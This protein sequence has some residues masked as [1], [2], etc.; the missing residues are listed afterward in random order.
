MGNAQHIDMLNK[1]VRI[2]N[3]W[4]RDNAITPDLSQTD[5]TGANLIGAYLVEANLNN[6]IL[7]DADI[8]NANLTKAQLNNASLVESDLSRATLIEAQ[9]DGADLNHTN[10]GH[11]N[12]R[13]ASL[14]KADLS[15]AILRNAN[16]SDVQLTEANLHS[17]GLTYADFTDAKLIGANLR[18]AL[19]GWT[20]LANTDISV[21]KGL[22]AIT[23]RGPSTV[24][25]D[26]LY[27]SRGDIPVVFLQGCGVP[28]EFITYLPSLVGA[29]QAIQFYSCFISYS[30]R[31]EEFSKRLHSRMRDAHLRVWYA[32]EDI[33][34]G[35]KL[36]EQIDTAIQLHDRLVLVLSENSLQSEWVMT[37]IRKA[38]KIENKE[39]RRKLFPIRLTDMETIRKWECFDADIGK[40]L[41]IEV[42]EYYIPDFS[43]WKNHDSFE[44]AF[45]RLLRDLKAEELNQRRA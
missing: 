2:W 26:T 34:G 1:G 9:L 19:L 25:I 42:R 12:L 7:A 10:L 6:T 31:D 27:K 15:W 30:H 39:K 3:Q 43:N 22:D 13:G 5:F 21:V 45:N 8:A 35:Q 36:H 33:K 11:A 32:P 37:E 16:L 14:I 41:A 18:R 24:G 29:R 4:I 40:D 20:K 28:D 38:R 44:A 23:H 17:A